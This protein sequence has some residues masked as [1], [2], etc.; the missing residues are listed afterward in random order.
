MP[1]IIIS[2]RE[3]TDSCTEKH[4]PNVTNNFQSV[5]SSQGTIY[6]LNSTKKKDA[7]TTMT[8]RV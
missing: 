7:G 8:L 3:W 6:L 4:I 2:V 5:P 1:V